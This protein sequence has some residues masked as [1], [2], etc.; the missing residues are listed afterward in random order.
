VGLNYDTIWH[1]VVTDGFVHS[2]SVIL[3]NDITNSYSS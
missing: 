1:A 2:T 3:Q